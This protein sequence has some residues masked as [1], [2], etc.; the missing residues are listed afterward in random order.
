MLLLALLS[1]IFIARAL[2]FSPTSCPLAATRTCSTPPTGAR[3]PAHKTAYWLAKGLGTSATAVGEILTG[4][5]SITPATALRLERFLGCSAEFW[6]N[7]QAAYDVEEERR[8][9][10]PVLEAIAPADL[11][12]LTHERQRA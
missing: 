8:R 9:L 12:A 5:R 10:A 3:Y 7:L 11:P 2:P 4:K 1:A 6:L